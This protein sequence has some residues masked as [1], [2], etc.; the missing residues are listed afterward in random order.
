M[1]TPDNVAPFAP[2]GEAQSE[3]R[4]TIATPWRTDAHFRDLCECGNVLAQCRCASPSKLV[5]VVSPCR[6]TAP[7]SQPTGAACAAP[8]P[9]EPVVRW[10][11]KRD[12]TGRVVTVF[13]LFESEG[14]AA[15]FLAGISGHPTHD[16]FRVTRVEIREAPL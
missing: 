14:A 3:Q 4:R 10:A 15:M 11:I 9:P 16:D 7:L 2:K 6:C 5:T 8:P 12:S 13:G 1:T